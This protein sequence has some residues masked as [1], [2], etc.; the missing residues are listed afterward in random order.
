MS[1][2]LEDTLE[3]IEGRA[4]KHS[5]EALLLRDRCQDAICE[6]QSVAGVSVFYVRHHQHRSKVHH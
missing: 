2:L 3:K 6:Q 5:E 1:K 4:G